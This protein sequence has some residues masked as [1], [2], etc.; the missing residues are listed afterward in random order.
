MR[1]LRRL[2]LG[3]LG[4]AGLL[5]LWQLAGRLG[6]FD[7]RFVPVP[8]Q[9]VHEIAGLLGIAEFRADFVATVLAW[10]IALVAA[11]LV[12]VPVGLLLGSVPGLRA[13]TSV[14]IEFLRP[15]PTVTLIPLVLVAFGD[16]AQI[17]IVLAAFASIWPIL[18]N[19]MYGLREVDPLLVDTA[20]AY[21]IGRL[22]LALG[23]RLPYVAPFAPTGIRLSA[24]ISLIVIVSTEF[25]S[26]S[27]IGFGS[28]VVL[29]GE[30]TGDM[31]MVV[32]GAVLAGLL[33]ALV[34]GLLTAV[35][36]R[37]LNWADGGA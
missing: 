19:V 9:V 32:G 28:Y 35:R 33:G 25:V 31:P 15:I 20:R 18:F 7:T 24:A 2:V 34:S 36:R 29:N 21:R 3:L 11:T 8:T 16:G 27:G 26:N 37:W 30:Q 12:A 5:L 6:W 13:A 4:L 22:R 14:I 10:L 1:L 17:K 23:V